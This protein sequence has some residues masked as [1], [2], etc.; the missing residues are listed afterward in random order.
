MKVNFNRAATSA[1][2]SKAVLE[3]VNRHLLH[4][5]DSVGRGSG[6]VDTMAAVLDARIALADLLN[7]ESPNHI[8][9]T[10]G[11]TESL[12]ILIGGLLGLQNEDTELHLIISV[13][14]HNA[15]A[16]PANALAERTSVHLH[17]IEPTPE[18]LAEI[19]GSITRRSGDL[20]KKAEIAVIMTHASNVFG[21]LLPV[22]SLFSAAKQCGAYTIL[23]ASQTLGHIP[24]Q[25]SDGVDAIAFTGHKGL[26]ALPGSGGFCIRGAFAD[27]LMPWKYG[28][29]GS[30][31]D[32]LQMPDF[33]PDKF[34]AGTP[35]IL[36]ILALGA[37][38]ADTAKHLREHADKEHL[39]FQ[40]LLAS[41][42][43]LPVNIQLV[44]ENPDTEHQIPVLSITAD[45]YDASLLADDL[46]KQ[47]GIQ[48][49][50]GLH[51]A[52]L[53]HRH[54]N[55]FPEGTLRISL[56]SDNTMEEIDYF[57]NALQT[58]LSL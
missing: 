19:L 2:K 36:G 29:T 24:V 37:A 9:F 35:N 27:K 6:A 23:D 1:T 38:A 47:Y 55:T 22:D 12:N 31:S 25:M 41:L 10:S 44:S 28:G 43:K 34:E 20:Q 42:R 58:L 8:V 26:K 46:D 57:T 11:A 48:T 21:N 56:N 52:P 5:M 49:R 32:S 54:R 15:V 17:I 7:A 18:A 13:F 14:E 3:T 40:Y 51:C 53:A 30:I 39:L 16:R 33:L 50:S 4:D 45:D